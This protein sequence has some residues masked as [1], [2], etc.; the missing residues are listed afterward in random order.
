MRRYRG[1]EQGGERGSGPGR[2]S[3]GAG[4]A[5]GPAWGGVAERRPLEAGLRLRSS[6][7]LER[8]RTGWERPLPEPREGKRRALQGEPGWDVGVGG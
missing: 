6:L 4:E 7:L 3:G 2:R 8:S 1:R 5:A